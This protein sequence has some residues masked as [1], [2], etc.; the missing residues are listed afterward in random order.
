MRSH[1]I[2][3]GWVRQLSIMP[4]FLLSHQ[5]DAVGITGKWRV[6]VHHAIAL[7][8]SVILSMSVMASRVEKAQ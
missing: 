3:G 2:T 7:K 1:L 6:V 8:T 5:T 4:A